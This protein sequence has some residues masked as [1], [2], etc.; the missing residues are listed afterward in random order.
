M[1][2]LPPLASPPETGGRKA[3]SEQVVQHILSLIRSGRLNPGDRLPPERLLAADFSVSRPTVREALRALSILGVLEINHGGGVFVSALDSADLL[4]PLDFFMSLGPENIAE[5]FD[6]RIHF[7]PTIAVL[8]TP[9]LTDAE[10][11]GLA[12]LVDAQVAAPGDA[13]LFFDTDAEFHKT[14]VAASGNL[15]LARI[16]KLMQVLGE[17]SRRSFLQH[18]MVRHQSIADHKTIMAALAS[19][20]ADAAGAAM[21]QHMINVRKGYR[22]TVGV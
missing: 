7:E 11:T 17:T 8:A 2:E 5:L 22:E 19:R 13:E 21:R 15:F 12:A 9:R 16:G 1:T 18:D 6:A 3:I 20:N 4:N 10:L 14:I